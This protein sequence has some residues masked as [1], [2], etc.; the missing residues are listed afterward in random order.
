[1]SEHGVI[2]FFVETVL[3]KTFSMPTDTA[4]RGVHE[5]HIET[6]LLIHRTDGWTALPYYWGSATDA[7]YIVT[8][9]AM[10][11][12]IVHDGESLEFEC[13]VPQKNSA[14]TVMRLFLCRI[15]MTRKI[16]ESLFL[17]R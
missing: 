3:V 13:G 15:R 16:S 8:A 5:T 14:L 12:A 1:M 4:N 6:R 2:E 7:S 10:D 11:I 17:S 9:K